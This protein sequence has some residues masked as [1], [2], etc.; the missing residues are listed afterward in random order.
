MRLVKLVCAYSDKKDSNNSPSKS[1]CKLGFSLGS[2]HAKG[3]TNLHLD[4]PPCE[5]ILCKLQLLMD[6]DYI[7]TVGHYDKILEEINELAATQIV[8]P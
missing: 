7:D 5:E 6:H 1:A 4:M 3:H 8:P 2:A